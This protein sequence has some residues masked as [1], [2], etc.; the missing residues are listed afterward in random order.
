MENRISRKVGSFEY[1]GFKLKYDTTVS[2]L[3][4]DRA[5]KAWRVTPMIMQ[6]ISTSDKSITPRLSLNLLDKPIF[7]HGRPW[8][9]GDEKSIF[10]VVIH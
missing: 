5:S 2:R 4:A 3:M 6:A 7:L 8:I 1:L 9:P 10:T